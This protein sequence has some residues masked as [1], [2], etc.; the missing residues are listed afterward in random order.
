MIIFF[1]CLLIIF[2]TLIYKLLI[3]R[4]TKAIFEKLVNI[5]SRFNLLAI[6][7][8]VFIDYKNQAPQS[9]DE[10][11]QNELNGD[12]CIFLLAPNWVIKQKQLKWNAIVIDAS[13]IKEFK[14]FEKGIY[15]LQDSRVFFVRDFHSYFLY[16]KGAA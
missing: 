7:H 6:N 3:L 12:V 8:Y 10:I 14:H 4:R 5:S 11:F 16:G 15:I 1:N 2:L 13:E 9:L